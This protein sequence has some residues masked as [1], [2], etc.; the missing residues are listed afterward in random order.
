[1][2]V[3]ASSFNILCLLSRR[4]LSVISLFG[5]HYQMPFGSLWVPVLP[6]DTTTNRTTIY[7]LTTLATEPFCFHYQ[8]ASAT[9]SAPHQLTMATPAP[10]TS[11]PINT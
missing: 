10:S 9:A 5:H 8:N 4:E 2:L 1:M 7:H 6:D 3:A 11:V